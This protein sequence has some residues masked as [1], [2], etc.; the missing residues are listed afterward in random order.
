M[1][2]AT[3]LSA[4]PLALILRDRV[5]AHLGQSLAAGAAADGVNY[6]WWQEFASQATG[7]EATL[8][9]SVVGF[10]ATLQNLSDL[11]DARRG[12]A[13]VVAVLAGYLLVWVFLTGGILDRYARQRA[14]RAHGFFAASGT[15]FW[16]LLRL[17][18]VA[19]VVYWWL[20]AY[21]HQWL[22]DTWYEDATRDLA[23]ERTAFYWRATLYVL[24]GALLLAV[25]L[26]VDPGG[27]ARVHRPASR[28]R[29]GS[30]RRQ[31]R[32]VPRRAQRMGAARARCRRRWHRDLAGV[33]RRSTV[34]AG[35]TPPEAPV[36]RVR[37][38][39]LSGVARP[40]ALRGEAG[41]CVAGVTR[42]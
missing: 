27:V 37:G 36:R 11:L 42:R 41:G 19:G 6:D 26:V 8:T 22:F 20:F 10:A 1:L 34:R 39:A 30:L 31:Q 13:A 25:N 2:A 28:T 16:R 3:L 23:V 18:I 24:F 7:L 40:R 12:T 14:T 33:R 4:L 38:R 29:L 35:A 17:A 9:P 21:V 5:E 15:Y 32:H